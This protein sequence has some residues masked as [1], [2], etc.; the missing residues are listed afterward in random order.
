MLKS[1]IRIPTRIPFW[2]SVLMQWLPPQCVLYFSRLQK[3]IPSTFLLC[4]VGK[5]VI[6]VFLLFYLLTIWYTCSFIL[7]CMALLVLPTY[8]ISHGYCRFLYYLIVFINNFQVQKVGLRMTKFPCQCNTFTVIHSHQECVEFLL[9]T[10]SEYNQIID[11]SIVHSQLAWW[12]IQC[13][14]FPFGHI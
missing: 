6:Q 4:T 9:T 8:I 13:L 5:V 10:I 1:P 14:F 3:V 2:L 7:I 11:K 12:V